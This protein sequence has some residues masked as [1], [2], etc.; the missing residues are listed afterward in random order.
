[1]KAVNLLPKDVEKAKGRQLSPPA[2][3]GFIAAVVVIVVL[4]GAFIRASA[5]VSHKRTQLDAARAELALVPPPA[6]PDTASA[7]LA[8]ERTQRIEALQGALNGRVSWDRVLREL[9]LVLPDDVW[10]TGLT[11]QAPAHAT[12]SVPTPG[13]PTTTTTTTTTSTPTTPGTTTAS[14]VPTDFAVN[15]QAFSHVSVARFLSRLALLPDLADVTL[16]HSTRT[17]VGNREAV[18]FSISAAVRIPGAT[19]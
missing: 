17:K 4:C 14:V 13:S 16:G 2:L 18:E 8:T 15:G 19:P 6:T 5:N 1:M 10:F 3:T 12:P 11:M 7:M 9:S